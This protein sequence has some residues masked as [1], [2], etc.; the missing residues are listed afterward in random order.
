M[1]QSSHYETAPCGCPQHPGRGVTDRRLHELW[2][3]LVV[4]QGGPA[5]LQARAL[6]VD[7]G[8]QILERAGRSRT[9]A[10]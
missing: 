10:G 7:P 5:G 6:Q 1:N 9:G 3:A 8:E 2:H 4:E